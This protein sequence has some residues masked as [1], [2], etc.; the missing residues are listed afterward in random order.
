MESSISAALN[1]KVAALA[2]DVAEDDYLNISFDSENSG[3]DSLSVVSGRDDILRPRH[4][5]VMLEL[6]T[7]ICRICP[8]PSAF[9][10]E[11]GQNE[12]GVKYL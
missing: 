9:A 3:F 1:S 7:S 8:C 6:G 4:F 12:D 2:Y 10:C 5:E 11:Y